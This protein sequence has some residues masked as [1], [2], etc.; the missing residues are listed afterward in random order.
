MPIFVDEYINEHNLDQIDACK[1]IKTCMHKIIKSKKLGNDNG[2]DRD[3]S[4]IG[5]SF[6]LDN[7]WDQ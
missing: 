6:V 4:K 1:K 3:D 5:N 7:C 2:L